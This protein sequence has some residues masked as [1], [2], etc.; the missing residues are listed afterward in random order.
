[1]EYLPFGENLVKIG[2][3]DPEMI[4]IKGVILKRN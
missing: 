3:V 2:V 4:G 1:M